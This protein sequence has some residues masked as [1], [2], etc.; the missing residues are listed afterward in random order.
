VLGLSRQFWAG[1]RVPPSFVYRLWGLLDT[2]KRI[3][4]SDVSS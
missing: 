2:T 3:R 1:A 4:M